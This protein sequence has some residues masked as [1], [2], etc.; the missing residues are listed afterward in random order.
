MKLKLKYTSI[1]ATVILLTFI[2]STALASQDENR[3][4]NGCHTY[5]PQ[6]IN[7]TTDINSIIVSPNEPFVVNI[8]WSGGDPSGVTEINWPTNF[9]NLIPSITRDNSLFNPNPRNSSYV[10]TPNGIVNSTLTAP[11][12][13]GTYTVRAY[14]SRG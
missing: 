12:T 2:T 4:C 9:T 5:S 10:S 3:A 13:P 14:A 1:I 8:S 6:S 7:I 11:Q